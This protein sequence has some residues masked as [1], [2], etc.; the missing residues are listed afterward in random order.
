MASTAFIWLAAAVLC[1][2]AAVCHF[3]SNALMRLLASEDP[4]LWR[5]L[6]EPS[7]VF[8]PP[9]GRSSFSPFVVDPVR[10]SLTRTPTWISR[11][12]AARRLLRVYRIASVAMLLAL[13]SLGFLAVTA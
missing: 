1:L 7:G 12:P 6:G 4:A 11:S 13:L 8:A 3:T 9:R 2:A 5:L 10:M